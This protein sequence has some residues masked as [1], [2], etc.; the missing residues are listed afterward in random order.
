MNGKNIEKGENKMKKFIAFAL[1]LVLVLTLVATAFAD[2]YPTVKFDSKSKNKSVK[3]GKTLTLKYKVNSGSGP[4][5][6]VFDSYG[7]PILRAGMTVYFKKGSK[8]VKVTDYDFT[9]KKTVKAKYKTKK[10]FTKGNRRTKFKVLA[11]SWYRPTYNYVVY[12]WQKYKTVKTNLYV[13]P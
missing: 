7:Y 6:K 12:G 5:Y 8:Q 10:I 13:N 4:F 3:Y 11:T 9:G 1:V 2:Y